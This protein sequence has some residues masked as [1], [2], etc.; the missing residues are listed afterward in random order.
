M[1]KKY[2]GAGILAFALSASLY[3]FYFP[4]KK[5][6]CSNIYRTFQSPYNEHKVVVYSVPV[7]PMMMPGSA[8]D[9]PGYVQL[10]NSSGHILEEK[11]VDMVQLIDDVQW[12]DDSVYI[13]LFADWKFVVGDP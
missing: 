10:Q 3:I 11:R 6:C 9:S 7:L 4:I 13:K 2:I 12:S 8:G 5:A 1:I